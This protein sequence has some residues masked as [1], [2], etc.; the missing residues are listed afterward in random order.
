MHNFHYQALCQILST[1]LYVRFSPLGFTSDS[2]HQA[3]S[4]S[5]HQA[6]H[7]ILSTRLYVQ[8]YPLGFT[9][10]SIHQASRPIHPILIIRLH[11]YSISSLHDQF[12]P[13]GFTLN[14]LYQASHPILTFPEEGEVRFYFRKLE[15][16]SEGYREGRL[17]G[18]YFLWC[19]FTLYG[20]VAIRPTVITECFQTFKR[21]QTHTQFH[22]YFVSDTKDQTLRYFTCLPA[23]EGLYR[24]NILFRFSTLLLPNCIAT[25]S[26]PRPAPHIYCHVY[27]FLRYNL[28]MHNLILCFY[29]Y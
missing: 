23:K 9:S 13:L 20:I 18:C 28:R 22:P 15:M 1:R 17:C 19:Q 16:Q 26:P 12:Y 8:F 3:L 27:S 5:L 10:N 7:Q 24:V 4:S 11:A 14:S 6:S 25:N 29:R 21:S 2:L